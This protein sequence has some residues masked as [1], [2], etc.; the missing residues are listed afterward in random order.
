[1]PSLNAS[2]QIDFRPLV[3]TAGCL[4]EVDSRWMLSSMSCRVGSLFCLTYLFGLNGAVAVLAGLT[5]RHCATVQT[6]A[7]A[8]M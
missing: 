5:L 6:P 3:S 1:M 4:M 2:R 7:D 8:R